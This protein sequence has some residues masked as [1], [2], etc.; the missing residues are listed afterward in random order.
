MWLVD[1][2]FWI[3]AAALIL[4]AHRRRDDSVR[5]G[6]RISVDY[7]LIMMPRMVLALAMAG[8]AAEL[9]PSRLVSH[10]LGG[11]SGFQGILIASMVGAAVPAGGIVAFPI[12]LAIYKVGVGVPQ[13]IAF[14]TSWAVFAVHRVL[15]F[16]IP[17]LGARFV[18][19]RF[20][21]S[22]LLPPLSGVIAELLVRMMPP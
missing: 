2:S 5:K 10:W 3:A 6:L 11:A 1:L 16:E 9:I 17:F 4:V 12:A 14:L 8:F 7:L 19:L 18:A 20:A 21:A 15:A 22:F 13:L